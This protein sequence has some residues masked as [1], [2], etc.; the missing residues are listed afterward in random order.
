MDRAPT[1]NP[2]REDHAPASDETILRMALPRLS[3]RGVSGEQ[4]GRT[5]VLPRRL[6]VGRADE[7]DL[8]LSDPGISRH[9]AEILRNE[10]KV[11][12]VDMES[13]NGT[14]VNDKRVVERQELHEGDRLSFDQQRFLLLG[15]GI[16]PERARKSPAVPSPKS[17]TEHL[18]NP[19]RAPKTA[20][21]L[22][23]VAL[24]LAA[25]AAWLLV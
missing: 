17:V 10:H 5:I 13:A 11:V 9:H 6:L 8:V 21:F 19:R 2:D 4:F 12:V 23:L 3:L 18:V 20:G 7:C 25:W 15:P 14:Y 16:N 22:A 1:D 24:G